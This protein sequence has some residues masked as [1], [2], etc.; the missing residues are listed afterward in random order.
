MDAKNARR[1]D[2][3]EQFRDAVDAFKKAIM[4]TPLMQFMEALVVWI[5][6]KIS[7]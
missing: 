4:E 7:K 2:D 3:F 1:K 6:N 5:N